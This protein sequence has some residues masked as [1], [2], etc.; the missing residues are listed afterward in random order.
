MHQLSQPVFALVEALSDDPFYRAI[1]IDYGDDLITRKRIL[2]LYFEYS[3]GEAARTGRCV[4][5]PRPELGA[6]AWIL[7]RP[8]DIEAQEIAAKS[9]FLAMILGHEGN[10]NYHRMIQAMSARAGQVVPGCAWYL[11]I[12]G[13]LPSAQGK[14]I[15][16]SLLRSTLEEASTNRIACYLETFSAKSISF[17][18]R[19]G[20]IVVAKHTEPVACSS[21]V[22]MCRNP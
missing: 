5:A 11:S 12:M 1:T 6:S 15:G 7:P 10:E 19:L 2:S 3:L 9:G 16:S 4:L 20:F 22:I 13:I 21:Y 14:G 8:A 18:E 17:Y